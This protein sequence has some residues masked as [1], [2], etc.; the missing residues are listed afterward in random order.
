MNTESAHSIAAGNH[1]LRE[2]EQIETVDAT[3]AKAI[4]DASSRHLD[5]SSVMD[6]V[7]LLATM[8]RL[9]IRH[10]VFEVRH[11]LMLNDFQGLCVLFKD[12]VSKLARRPILYTDQ[13][14]R[15]VCSC[16]RYRSDKKLNMQ[17]FFDRIPI[18]L[19]G[20]EMKKSDPNMLMMLA[21]GLVKLQ[22]KSTSTG[23]ALADFF[24]NDLK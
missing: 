14:Y 1:L 11:L 9:K 8:T 17:P 22:Y 3:V 18:L 13:L 7:H 15:I 16:A 23:I 6:L 20:E 2:L 5:E 19:S 12:A 4:I 21:D 24:E 10:P